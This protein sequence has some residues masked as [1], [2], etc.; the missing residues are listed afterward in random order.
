MTAIMSGS[1]EAICWTAPQRI[2]VKVI[3]TRHG[4]ACPGHLDK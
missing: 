2:P 3:Q 1:V 4:R